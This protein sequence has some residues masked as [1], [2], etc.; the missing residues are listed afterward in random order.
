MSAESE[1]YQAATGLDDGS[2]KD[3]TGTA[4][5]FLRHRR[6]EFKTFLHF[7]AWAWPY[8]PKY[9]VMIA[10]SLLGVTISLIPPW[11]AKL[12]VDYAFP[13][14][15]WTIFWGVFFAYLVMDFF[16]RTSG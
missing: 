6:G 1:L 8:W 3:A 15:N 14:R 11:L 16:W 7:L 9:L 13:D 4:G 12:L 5:L 10:L 2:L